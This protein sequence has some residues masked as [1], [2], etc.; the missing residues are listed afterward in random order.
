MQLRRGQRLPLTELNPL[1]VAKPFQIGLVIAGVQA[2]VDYACFGLDAQQ[3]LS[4]ERYMVFITSQKALVKQLR[5][6]NL[7]LMRLLLTVIWRTCLPRS[8]D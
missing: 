2:D 5:L 1:L 6:A 4:D 7:R 8:K 3:K